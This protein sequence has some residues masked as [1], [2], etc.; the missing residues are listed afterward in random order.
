M[1]MY[2]YYITYFI[3]KPCSMANLP[4]VESIDRYPAINACLQAG[5]GVGNETNS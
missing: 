3:D 2:D 4:L 5:Q 1:I